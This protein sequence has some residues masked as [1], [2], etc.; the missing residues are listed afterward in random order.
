LGESPPPTQE[1]F[2]NELFFE[3]RKMNPSKPVWLEDESQ[4]IGSINLPNPLWE[5]MRSAYLR[6]LEIPFEKRLNYITDV[7]GNFKTEDLKSATLRIQKRLGGLETKNT[8]QFLENND[9]RSAFSILLKYYD[10]FYDRATSR[11]SPEKIEKISFDE[12][13]PALIASTLISHSLVSI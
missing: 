5:Q 9:L 4:R 12:L 2:E 6:Y 7:Y 1:Q 8:M 11:R 10:K 13:N 3:F